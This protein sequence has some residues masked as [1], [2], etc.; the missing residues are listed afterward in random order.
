MIFKYYLKV[1]AVVPIASSWGNSEGNRQ[2]DIFPVGQ[3]LEQCTSFF[4]LLELYSWTMANGL[5]GWTG[6]G[7]DMT[8]KWMTTKFTKESCGSTSLNGQKKPNMNICVLCECSTED[9]FSRGEF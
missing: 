5:A 9:K 1:D 8:R 7:R 6:L 2:R 3:N 4:T